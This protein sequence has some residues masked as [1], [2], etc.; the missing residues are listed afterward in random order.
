MT[1]KRIEIKK[2]TKKNQTKK[3]STSDF[4]RMFA[5]SENAFGYE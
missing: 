2:E 3:E 1:E 4:L 5:R